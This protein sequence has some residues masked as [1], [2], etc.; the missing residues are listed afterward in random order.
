MVT[1]SP[2][3]D[4]E[5]LNLPAYRLIL[6]KVCPSSTVVH[7]NKLAT[8]PRAFASIASAVADMVLRDERFVGIAEI[9]SRIDHA[10]GRIV[11]CP[12]VMEVRL[13]VEVENA[14]RVAS[15]LPGH[16]DPKEMP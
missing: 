15:V 2:Y 4:G 5:V 3:P 16:H 14:L 11:E 8:I 13:V 1:A 7:K 6:S 12:A 9:L 10:G